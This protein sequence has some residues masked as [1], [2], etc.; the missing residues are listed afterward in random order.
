[1]SW[2]SC[3]T[4]MKRLHDAGCG[5][6]YKMVKRWYGWRILETDACE[7]PPV[8][9]CRCQ[10][11][12]K[13]WEKAVALWFFAWGLLGLVLTIHM[14]VFFITQEGCLQIGK[15]PNVSSYGTHCEK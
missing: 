5:H 9:K 6:K 10:Q 13:L 7:N 1:M 8:T 12:L 3:M 11:D 14:T 15:E 2:S 4:E